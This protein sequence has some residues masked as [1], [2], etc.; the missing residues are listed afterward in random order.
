MENMKII[1]SIKAES[2]LFSKKKKNRTE[3]IYNKYE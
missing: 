1:T 3:E 2:I